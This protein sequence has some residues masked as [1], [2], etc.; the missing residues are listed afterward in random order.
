MKNKIEKEFKEFFIVSDKGEKKEK[1]WIEK[2]LQLFAEKGTWDLS[3][4]RNEKDD[5]L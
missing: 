2:W 3:K 5:W 4:Y 1:K